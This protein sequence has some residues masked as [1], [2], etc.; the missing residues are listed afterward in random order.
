MKKIII[1][2]ML[3]IASFSFAQIISDQ[4][5]TND[6]KQIERSKIDTLKQPEQTL[7]L[8]KLELFLKTKEN[9]ENDFSLPHLVYSEN[10]HLSSFFNPDVNIRKNGFTEIQSSTGSLQKIQNFRNIYKAVYKPGNIFYEPLNY[11]LPVALTETYMGL[12]DN[13]MNNIAVS[14]MKGDAFGIPDLDLQIDYLG[15][16]GL[17]LSLENEISKN[18][19]LYL[20]YDTGFARISFE[21][22]TIDQRLSGMK[23]INSYLFLNSSASYKVREYLLKVENKIVDLGMR[24]SADN[25]KIEE[26]F[27]KQS[28]VLQILVSKKLQTANHK[29][30]L[31]SELIHA[32]ITNNDLSDQS[33]TITTKQDSL[34]P[35]FFFDHESKI[36]A[37]KFGNTLTYQ[38]KNNYYLNS[39][40]SKNIF[41]NLAIFT[42]Y[43]TSA[44]DLKTSPSSILI[45]DNRSN[46]GGGVKIDLPFVTTKFKLGQHIINDLNSVFYE[47]QNKLN[48][49]LSQNFKINFKT[50][51]RKEQSN[52]LVK[53][54]PNILTFPEWQTSDQLELTY[55]LPYKNAVKIGFKHIYHSAFTFY[56]EDPE[57]QFTS[58][59]HNLDAYFKLQ[60]TERF[61]IWA[62]LINLTNTKTMFNN[63]SHPGTHINFNVHWIFVN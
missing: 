44:I 36:F 14:L 51:L 45:L 41:T 12:G 60:I 48:F 9:L 50:W 19:R 55:N 34:Y 59:S 38:N 30:T 20:V 13:D 49:G 11:S 8:K 56:L 5:E 31:S 39:E 23:N 63:F 52:F 43:R 16:D 4:D 25:Y 24:F 27:R 61:E 3:F 2:L 57:S 28:D 21:H 33:T 6:E 53:K 1:L 62:D 15:E 58:D 42:E 40:I 26:Q 17:W 35:I 18:L 46:L 7:L 37:F 32:D 10:F 22:T 47:L 29:L 54:D